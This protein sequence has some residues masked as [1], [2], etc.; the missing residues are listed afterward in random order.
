MHDLCIFWFFFVKKIIFDQ[1]LFSYC[2]D[3]ST[4]RGPLYTCLVYIYL[5]WQTNRSTK[6]H[7]NEGNYYGPHLVNLGAK[8]FI[9]AKYSCNFSWN[10]NTGPTGCSL[11][12]SDCINYQTCSIYESD[13]VAYLPLSTFSAIFHHSL[14]HLI[15]LS[16]HGSTEM[17]VIYRCKKHWIIYYYVYKHSLVQIF[18][19][20][21]ISHSFTTQVYIIGNNK[22]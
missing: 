13:C 4:I 18:N 22:T 15:V 19:L 1:K 17:S 12:V 8:M 3:N 6:Q 2:W 21:N 11:K 16:Q 9:A 5:Y 20:R 7:T 14:S 10:W